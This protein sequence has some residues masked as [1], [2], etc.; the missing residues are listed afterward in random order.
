[1]KIMLIYL[2]Y[3]NFANDEIQ[4]IYLIFHIILIFEIAT[5]IMKL[6]F[7]VNL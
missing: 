2:K 6:L 3:V 1:M 7:N 4:F 5:V